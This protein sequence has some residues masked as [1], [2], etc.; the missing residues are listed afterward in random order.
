[1]SQ[2]ERYGRRDLTYSAWHRVESTRR[3]VGVEKAQALGMI[4]LDAVPFVEYDDGSKEPL[5]LIETARDVGQSLKVAT[6]TKNLAKRSGLS[7]FTVLYT[8]GQRPNPADPAWPDIEVFRVARIWPEP[9]GWVAVSPS[10]WAHSLLRIRTRAAR[11]LDDLWE[12]LG[13]GPVL[14]DGQQSI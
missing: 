3:F 5:A 2:R 9:T 4:D 1:M 7:A 14:F 10:L 13:P 6:V 8:P 11:T 12:S